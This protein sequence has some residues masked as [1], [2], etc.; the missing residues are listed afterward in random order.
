[1]LAFYDSPIGRLAFEVEGSALRGIR[2]D[3]GSPALNTPEDA[4]SRRTLEAVTAWLDTYFTG[5]A[6]TAHN[7]PAAAATP[8]PPLP[9]DVQPAGT[10]YQRLVWETARRIPFGHTTTYGK[11]A[12]IIGA[13]RGTPTSARAVGGALGKNPILVVV[14]CHRV[15]GADSSLTGFSAGI[16]R[17][18]WLLNHES[19]ATA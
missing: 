5:G 14:P 12:R 17:K 2:V 1:M 7:D 10:D 19:A 18:R 9:F 8:A 6:Q 15:V 4:A 16:Q 3:D 11:L 13:K